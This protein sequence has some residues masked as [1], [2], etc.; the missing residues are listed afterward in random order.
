MRRARN[1]G[2][3]TG[4]LGKQLGAVAPLMLENFG[5]PG[6]AEKIHAYLG[7]LSKR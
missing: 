1:L 7:A 6:V 2:P 4:T 5:A 3:A